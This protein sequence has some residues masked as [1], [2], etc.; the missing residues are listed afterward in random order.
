MRHVIANSEFVHLAELSNL[1]RIHKQIMITLPT[2]MPGKRRHGLWNN[3]NALGIDPMKRIGYSLIALGP[4]LD[5]DK[6][7]RGKAASID[8]D[9]GLARFR[10]KFL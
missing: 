8:D 3:F 10:E 7:V 2:E 6:A 9:Q 4:S 5:C 1:L